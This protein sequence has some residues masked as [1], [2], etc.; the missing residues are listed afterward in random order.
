MAICFPFAFLVIAISTA[1][2]W[3]A[4]LATFTIFGIVT[5]VLGLGANNFKQPFIN[6]KIK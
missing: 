6:L 1:N 5:T 3:L 4:F 2:V